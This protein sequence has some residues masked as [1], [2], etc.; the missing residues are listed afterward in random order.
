MVSKLPDSP[1][2]IPLDLSVGKGDLWHWR[3]LDQNGQDGTQGLSHSTVHLSDFRGDT[4]RE[5]PPFQQISY[6]DSDLSGLGQ[7][8]NG[9]PD[10]L[11]FFSTLPLVI[12]PYYVNTRFPPGRCLSQSFLYWEWLFPKVQPWAGSCR[13]TAV[14]IL[15]RA[16]QAQSSIIII[17]LQW[18]VL[19][20]QIAMSG[21]LSRVSGSYLLNPSVLECT[22][23]WISGALLHSKWDQSWP[24]F[25]TAFLYINYF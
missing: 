22:F 19:C 15:Q 11:N 2:R 18:Y 10:P 8:Y 23:A 5:D 14:S 1:S 9:V 25:T 7:R 17:V 12:F 24:D 20:R 3:Y 16:V 6:T 21:R 4:W 13:P